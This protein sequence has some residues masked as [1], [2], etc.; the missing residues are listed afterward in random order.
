MTNMLTDVFQKTRAYPWQHFHRLSSEKQVVCR[1]C[2]AVVNQVHKSSTDTH[3]KSTAF[4]IL[5]EWK[6]KSLMHFSKKSTDRFI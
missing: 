2:P 6:Y 5:L 3:Y 1:T 4:S